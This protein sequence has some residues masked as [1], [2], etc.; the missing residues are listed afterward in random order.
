MIRVLVWNENWHESAQPHVAELYPDGIHGAIA[1][2]LTE[3]LGDEVEV[4]TATLDEPEHGLT[5]EALAG[6]DVL[7]WWGHVKHGD[8]AD[9]VAARVHEHV[10]G[11]L[12][13]IVLHSGHYSRIFRALMGT[14]CGL[15]WR[16]EGEREIVWTID[17]THPIAVGIEQPFVIEAQ[18]MYGEHFDVPPPEELVFASWFAGGEVFR[19][20]MTFR[21]GRGKIFYFSPGDQEYPV[22]RHPQVQQVLANAVRWAVPVPG[23]RTARE[24]PN[25]PRTWA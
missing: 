8:V 22:Y 9:E 25:Q 4:R 11:G 17:P 15:S 1:A 5:E 14:T 23:E 24:A 10:L 21:R 2:G 7:L 18:E 13:L 6:T 3:L 19:S 20:G 12:G 16:N